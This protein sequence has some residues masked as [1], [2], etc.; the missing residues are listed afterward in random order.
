MC[1]WLVTVIVF[2][3]MLVTVVIAMYHTPLETRYSGLFSVAC[4]LGILSAVFV[5]PLS[6][7]VAEKIG[8]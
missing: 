5:M 6:A 3:V 7:L 8:D 2:L 4:S 1:R